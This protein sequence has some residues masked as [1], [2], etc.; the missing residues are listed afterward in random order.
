MLSG[1]G[2]RLAVFWYCGACALTLTFFT[3]GATFAQDQAS[4]PAGD[5]RLELSVFLPLPVA[6]THMPLAAVVK[7]TNTTAQTVTVLTG[8]TAASSLQFVV[9][10]PDGT[11]MGPP[12][13]IITALGTSITGA[14]RL[15]AG[16]AFMKDAVLNRQCQFQEPGT[17]KVDVF[18][19]NWYSIR[20]PLPAQS[21]EKW[22]VLARASIQVNLL[23]NTR[24]DA[25]RACERLATG[26]D[27]GLHDADSPQL[28][29]LGP[30]DLEAERRAE[31]LL[32]D[33]LSYV[34]DEVALPY[35]APLALAGYRSAFEGIA[36][37][38]TP[39][40]MKLLRD[41]ASSRQPRVAQA[42]AAQLA[43]LGEPP[44]AGAAGSPSLGDH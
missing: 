11:V 35:L 12:A 14:R 27:Q 42:A 41:L 16:H 4:Q 5:I 36:R 22:P 7:V 20:G 23:N 39:T 26:W 24:G 10:Q 43:L 21:P 3:A 33:L 37:I 1:A 18:L 25:E 13:E 32:P 29:S 30:M 8:T 2:A 38:G 31:E 40:A 6:K 34:N 17:Y 19:L 44:G 9:T 15:D 28:Y